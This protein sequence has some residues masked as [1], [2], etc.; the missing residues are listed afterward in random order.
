M[1]SKKL[2]IKKSMPTI[3]TTTQKKQRMRSLGNP[4]L[5]R[6]ANCFF[7]SIGGYGI[8]RIQLGTELQFCLS[9]SCKIKYRRSLEYTVFGPKKK[10]CT[11]RYIDVE[12]SKSAQFKVNTMQLKNLGGGKFE[13]MHHQRPC[14][15]RLCTPRTPCNRLIYL[16]LIH[17]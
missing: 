1:K 16:S 11:S 12:V 2:K 7:Y 10:R 15:S 6:P 5:S 17:I 8:L 4:I 3:Y 13:T 9:H 14:T